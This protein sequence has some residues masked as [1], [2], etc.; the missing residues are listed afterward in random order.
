MKQKLTVIAAA[1]NEGGQVVEW[2]DHLRWVDR[3]VVV[4]TGSRDDTRTLLESGGAEVL[5]GAPG[6]IHAAKNQARLAVGAGWVLDLDLDERVPSPLAEEI[7]SVLDGSHPSVAGRGVADAFVAYRVPY[8]HYV[9]G[10]WLEHGGWR[11]QHLRLYRAERARYPETRAHSTLEVDGPT[12]ALAH[13]AVHFA[14]PLIHDF[15]VKMNR[16]TS[17]DAPLLIEHG[18]G[19]LRNRPPL[20]P[21]RLAWMRASLSVFWNRYIKCA[22]FRD[23]MPGF[24]I[25]SLLAYYNFVEQAKVW[26]ARRQAERS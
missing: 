1:S 6:L 10:R 17:Q 24:L 22:G 21:Q 13:F 18:R 8:R 16:Y 9:F 20:P 3:V 11:T 15:V 25:A 5:T 7:R 12:E 19:G 2:L 14:N 23:G 4:D 26:E